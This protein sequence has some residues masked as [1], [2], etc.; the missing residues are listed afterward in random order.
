MSFDREATMFGDTF[1]D[2]D[3]WSHGGDSARM[4]FDE[5]R[6]QAENNR[7]M[8]F[9]NAQQFTPSRPSR[10]RP[11]FDSH[12]P[13]TDS[14]GRTASPRWTSTEGQD[15]AE[16]PYADETF[17]DTSSVGNHSSGSLRRSS[18]GSSTA[19]SGSGTAAG[20]GHKP[21][22]HHIPIVVEGVSDGVNSPRARSP[23]VPQGSR[24]PSGQSASSQHEEQ[25]RSASRQSKASEGRNSRASAR[26]TSPLSS[27]HSDTNS[28]INGR[29][30]PVLVE[31]MPKVKRM[32]SNSSKG[33]QE[34][35]ENSGPYVTRIPLNSQGPDATPS[36]PP[37]PD[38]TQVIK[39]VMEELVKLEIDVNE[40]SGE[41]GDKQYRYL[42]EML[43]RCMIRL[44]DVETGGD[45]NI[46][47]AR[48]E[49]VNAVHR[50]VGLLESKNNPK[51][52]EKAE[53]TE[54]PD[55]ETDLV[56]EQEA[57]VNE[58]ESSAAQH[59]ANKLDSQETQSESGTTNQSEVHA[60]G[61]ETA[62]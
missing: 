32:G 24:H 37:K 59:E 26:S 31:G 49:A 1:S 17:S 11:S 21:K 46:R 7:R 54:K 35:K 5:M 36:P 27:A 8:F 22:V 29:P 42:D 18:S 9:D 51:C 40:Y 19:S 52:Q 20:G 39:S 3:D 55:T 56:G 38:A 28:D 14:R 12:S 10:F 60:I 23:N 45:S 33:S 50:I 41:K 13:P 44:D 15:R 57:S 53:T 58:N 62:V 30:I 61:S 4:R 47:Q 25:A 34:Q 16:R 2:F 43:T 48:K 6:K